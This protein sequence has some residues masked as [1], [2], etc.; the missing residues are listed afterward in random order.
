MVKDKR[1]GHTQ[2]MYPRC[3]FI[4]NSRFRNGIEGVV[5][6]Y[7][8]IQT[9][10][11]GDGKTIIHVAISFDLALPYRLLMSERGCTSGITI[12]CRFASTSDNGVV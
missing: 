11:F 10:L 4:W 12:R 8:V 3:Y 7:W 1:Q 2:P 9:I 5:N 6:F